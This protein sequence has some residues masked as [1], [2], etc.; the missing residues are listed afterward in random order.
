[1]TFTKR[2]ILNIL[3]LFQHH[4]EDLNIRLIENKY[5]LKMLPHRV[6]LDVIFIWNEV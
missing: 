5:A 1:M 2:K 4:E 3:D 6:L